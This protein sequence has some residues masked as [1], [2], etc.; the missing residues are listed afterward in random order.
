MT[1]NAN[2]AAPAAALWR[3]L[4]AP[5]A[6]VPRAALVFVRLALPKLARRQLIDAVRLQLGQYLPPGPF[7]FVCRAQPAGMVAVWA[8]PLGDAAGGG[9]RRL[10][11]PLL[12]PLPD[13]A[14]LLLQRH[15]GFEAQ[16][17]LQGELA[18]SRWFATAPD[19]DTW[20]G[21]VRGCGLDPLAHPLPPAKAAAP[22]GAP[23]QDWLVGSNLPRPDPW[24]G[25]RW[26]LALLVAGSVLA[27]AAGAHLQTRQQL[28]EDKQLLQSLRAAHEAALQAR[29]RYE[30]VATDVARLE[31]LVPKVT[32]LELLDRLVAGGALAPA[33]GAASA[34]ALAPRLS[35]WDYRSGQL[36]LT[37][38]LPEGGASFL[39]V[40][41]RLEQTPGLTALRVGQD[42]AGNTLT[43]SASVPAALDTAP[44][45]GL[46]A[47]GGR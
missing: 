46:S 24:R 23:A 11:E 14:V 4:V 26:Q 5:A 8:W 31:E 17:W 39:D 30:G 1:T 33:A 44:A 34:A 3:R 18:H 25:W 13:A 27:F 36:K 43:V 9:A 45:Q 6:P 2:P 16:H 28:R 21:F 47:A 37:I 42:S 40:T 19:D 29:A 41:R 32:Q 12:D 7:G 15:P 20:S 38:E 35:A 22:L 10:P